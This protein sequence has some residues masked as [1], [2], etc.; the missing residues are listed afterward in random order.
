MAASEM[1]GAGPFWRAP[2]SRGSATEVVEISG[3]C[4]PQMAWPSETPIFSLD[5]EGIH[6]SIPRRINGLQ[7]L[8]TGAGG[9]CRTTTSREQEAI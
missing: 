2:E 1:T 3:K 4:L 8:R 9:G 7:S 6:V 5:A